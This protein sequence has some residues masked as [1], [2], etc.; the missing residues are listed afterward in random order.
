MGARDLPDE[1]VAHQLA[2]RDVACPRQRRGGA[3]HFRGHA[4]FDPIQ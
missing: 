4:D 1:K 3:G 2:Q